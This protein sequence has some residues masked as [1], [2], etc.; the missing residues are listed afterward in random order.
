MVHLGRANQS[1]SLVQAGE[2]VL[3]CT[4]SLDTAAMFP[5]QYISIYLVEV[6]SYTHFLIF[7]KGI[8]HL[9]AMAL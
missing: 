9:K 1:E 2:G 4:F 3:W 5:S 8:S 6:F 7:T